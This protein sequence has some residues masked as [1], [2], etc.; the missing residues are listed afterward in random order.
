MAWKSCD[1]CG[2][3]ANKEGSIL[4]RPHCQKIMEEEFPLGAKSLLEPPSK[5][6]AKTSEKTTPI[7]SETPL[8]IEFFDRGVLRNLVLLEV[9][10]YYG[11]SQAVEL[12]HLMVLKCLDSVLNRFPHRPFLEEADENFIVRGVL[13]DCNAV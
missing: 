6:P 5:A 2:G 1:I 12:N 10:S 7:K 11:A 3:H 4:H 9:R 8:R 13:E